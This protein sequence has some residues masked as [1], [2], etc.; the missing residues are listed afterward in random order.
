MVRSVRVISLLFGLAWLLWAGAA[1]AG[2]IVLFEQMR[3]W[4][5]SHDEESCGA[6]ATYH[7]A[8]SLGFLLLVNGTFTVNVVHEGWN[9]PDGDGYTMGI[10]F[11]RGPEKIYNA[12]ASG[13]IVTSYF[14]FDREVFKNIS[15]SKAMSVRIGKF[16]TTLDLLDSQHM[17]PEL[18]RCI[19]LVAQGTNPYDTGTRSSGNSYR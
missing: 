16:S 15:M 7:R 10:S 6:F 18:I 9:I 17:M 13:T 11:D 19:A 3:Y 1:L 14:D 12:R 2:E 8:D 4:K 5:I